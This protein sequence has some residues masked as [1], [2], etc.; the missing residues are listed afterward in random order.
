M[1]ASRDEDRRNYEELARFL[2]EHGV[3]TSED[4]E[5]LF[6]HDG[7]SFYVEEIHEPGELRSVW[8]V[9]Y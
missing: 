5:A 1:T 4:G 3:Y 8:R 9:V 6:M 2:N 7:S